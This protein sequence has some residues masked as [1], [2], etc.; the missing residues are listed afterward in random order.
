MPV[1]TDFREVRGAEAPRSRAAPAPQPVAAYATHHVI[2]TAIVLGVAVHLARQ[3]STYEH[4]VMIVLGLAAVA[5]LE[6]TS[7]ARSFARL[8]AW[9]KR[10]NLREQRAHKTRRA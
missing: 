6:R 8:A 1:N 5:G 4:A 2:M 9:E 7:R 3:R 10:R